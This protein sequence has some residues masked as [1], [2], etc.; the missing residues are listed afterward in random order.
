MFFSLKNGRKF[1]FHSFVLLLM[2]LVVLCAYGPCLKGPFIWDDLS[3][4][5][6]NTRIGEPFAGF[7]STL[8]PSCRGASSSFYYRPLQ[9]F[10]YFLDY[11]IWHFN[12]FG[13]HLTNLLIHLL[14][15]FLLFCL[16]RR[17]LNTGKGDV[18]CG[19]LNSNIAVSMSVLFLVHP[20]GV[21][22]VAY[23]SGRADLL[24]C[25][26]ILTS[27]FLLMRFTH[28][29]RKIFYIGSL[30]FFFA[31]LLSKESAVLA[32]CFFA[33]YLVFFGGFFK[34]TGGKEKVSL[35]MGF[36]VVFFVYLFSRGLAFYSSGRFDVPIVSSG[37]LVPVFLKMISLYL[38][39]FL[40]PLNPHLGRILEIQNS[41]LDPFVIVS[42]L[43]LSGV[44]LLLC[45]YYKKS[46]LCVFFG[47]AWFGLWILPLSAFDI[48]YG[49]LPG[50]VIMPEN[51][52]YVACAGLL[53]AAACFFSHSVQTGKNIPG[54]EKL[55]FVAIGL[56]IIS[57]GMV[58]FYSSGVFSDD[59]VF[60]KHLLKFE[61]NN[62]SAGLIYKNLGIA[63]KNRGCYKEA[64]ENYFLAL[65]QGEDPAVYHNLGNIYLEQGRLKEARLQYLKAI[66][67]NPH[68]GYSYAGLGLV[69][70][71][72]GQV[73]NAKEMFEA[74]LI[75]SQGD[76][77][78]HALIK[79]ILSKS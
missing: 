50:A 39:L 19:G 21:T 30:A 79:D 66:H 43:I 52:L 57:I 56:Y 12:P 46:S 5:V 11:R 49:R 40:I 75:V 70:L 6:N 25:F 60:Y 72:Q 28:S 35:A 38:V 15:A 31:A 23:I 71:R 48:L 67:L 20:M 4:I 7:V 13:Y 14:N 65:A 33:A 18:H 69:S 68:F 78:L 26:F 74:A 24:V 41:F 1:F 73:E 63:Y 8:Y 2:L 3:L 54:K 22:S 29:A 37:F 27:L 61:K 58:T 51:N 42:C 34:K 32:L 53:F 17:F 55:F 16:L 45:R 62:G 64:V 36:C 44:I 9:A 10:S 47:L 76:M 77:R 59:I